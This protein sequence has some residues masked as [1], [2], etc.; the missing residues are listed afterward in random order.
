MKRAK[1]CRRDLRTILVALIA[2]QNL[3][4]NLPKWQHFLQQLT[5]LTICIYIYY[6]GLI[7]LNCKQSQNILKLAFTNSSLS[8]R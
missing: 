5:Y 3:E 8:L 7:V 2:R 4:E 6:Q 1:L